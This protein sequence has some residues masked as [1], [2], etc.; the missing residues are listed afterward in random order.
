MK[1]IYEHR[2]LEDTRPD[3]TSLSR[4]FEFGI[5]RGCSKKDY[6]TR[7]TCLQPA[8]NWNDQYLCLATFVGG[9]NILMGEIYVGEIRVLRYQ[10]FFK[11]NS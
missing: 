2:V 10:L 11:V 5:T 6:R 9:D 3:E 7:P 4:I 1:H 8:G